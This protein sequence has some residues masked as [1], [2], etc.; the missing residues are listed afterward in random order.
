MAGLERLSVSA[1]AMLVRKLSLFAV[2]AAGIAL[3]SVSLGAQRHLAPTPPMGWNDWAHYQCDINS[4]TV[5][6]NA[7]ALVRSGLAAR[8]YD[9]VTIDDCW[10][11]KER[12]SHG[13]LQPDPRRFPQGIRPVAAAIH[14][15]GLRFGIYE[16]A[17]YAT[18][19]GFAGSGSPR[20][21]GS[22][23]FPADARLFAAWGVDYLKLDGC[24]VQPA[25]GAAGNAAYRAA[26]RS[27]SLALERTGRAI[28]FSESAPAY[29]QGTP[30]WYDVLGWVGR[31]GQLW[32]EGTDIAVYD[33]RQPDRSRFGSV[34]W[35]YA[36]NLQLGRFQKPGNWND[37]DFII[38]GDRGM[39]LAET[40]TQLALWSMMSAPLILSSNLASLSPA[41]IAVLGNRA[42]LSVDQDP[43]GVMATLVRRSASMDLLL[44][45]LRD[46]DFAV[47]VL[48]RSPAAVRFELRPAELGF[49]GACRLEGR[50]LWTGAQHRSA[51]A[52]AAEVEAHGTDIWKIRPAHG[53]ETP[54]RIGVITRIMPQVPQ[55]PED[56]EDY[57]RCLAAPGTVQQCTG[58]PAQTWRIRPDGTL[59]A[60]QECL[61][62]VG[63][64]VALAKCRSTGS[65]RWRYTLPGNLVNRE[66][67]LCLTGPASGRLEVRACGHN[68]ASQI[69]TLPSHLTSQRDVL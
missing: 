18:C 38:G 17:G 8:G 60:G 40:R 63:A 66:S 42:V 33:P 28:V 46:G 32:R 2:A 6:A 57:T 29:F 24:N 27:E 59:R 31:Y 41:A 49:G 3:P 5:L 21:G 39:T 9:T 64:H 1:P 44:K 54:E 47:A 67:R 58:S 14:A 36:Y 50:D 52:L 37:A 48:N 65:Q 20:G 19:G 55:M 26:Y 15:L 53:C 45:P 16:D 69:W 61:T 12:D 68:L 4:D 13:K 56:T 11:L 34:L 30:E 7:R 10:M 62:Q 51:A 35:N 25:Q 23:H 22:P 43:L